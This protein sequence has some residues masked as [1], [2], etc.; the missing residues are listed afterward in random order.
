MDDP[1]DTFPVLKKNSREELEE[2]YLE[3]KNLN[4][5]NQAKTGGGKKSK[6]KFF[7]NKNKKR[8]T[9]KRKN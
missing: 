8:K 4:N 7:Y 5:S 1:P 9:K 2:E 6:K 3:F